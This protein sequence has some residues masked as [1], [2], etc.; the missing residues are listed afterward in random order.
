MIA[1]RCVC[2]GLLGATLGY[3]LAI[4]TAA[5]DDTKPVTVLSANLYPD[6]SGGQFYIEMPIS[7]AQLQQ[8]ADDINEGRRLK[9][10]YLVTDNNRSPARGNCVVR[11]EQTD[12][13]FR[14]LGE[15]PAFVCNSEV[16]QAFLN[17]IVRPHLAAVYDKVAI[18]ARISLLEGNLKTLSDENDALTKRIDTLETV[19]KKLGE[20]K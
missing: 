20:G 18:D 1:P 3:L 4:D 13:D 12:W 19:V 8:F 16:V 9:G 11:P 5:A 10:F 17:S 14:N 2:F 15:Q 6:S 7:I